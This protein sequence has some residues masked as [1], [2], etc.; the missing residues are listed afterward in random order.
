M[1]VKSEGRSATGLARKRD[2]TNAHFPMNASPPLSTVHSDSEREER[3]LA[4]TKGAS[5]VLLP[6]CTR[7]LVGDEWRPL[8]GYRAAEIRRANEQI[9]REV[10]RALAEALRAI[11]SKEFDPEAVDES[12]EDDRVVLGGELETMDDA[13]LDDTVRHVSVYARVDPE[14]K[15]RIV[16][17][18]QRVGAT[19]AMTGDSVN[20]VPALERADIGVA[21][22]INGTDVSKEAADMVLADDIYAT[23][24]AAVEVGRAIYANIRKFLRYLLSCNINARSDSR[25]AFTGMFTNR[26]LW[27]A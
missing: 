13:Q 16:E 17:S 10:L 20:D 22:G 8:T 1:D 11:P 4:F 9:A 6:R 24:V 18:S 19:V 5:D 27:A 7:E 25:S 14:H 2:G 23:I 12:I 26:W 21:T 15:L 3:V